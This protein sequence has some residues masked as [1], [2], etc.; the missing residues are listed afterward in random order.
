MGLVQVLGVSGSSRVLCSSGKEFVVESFSDGADAPVPS[1]RVQKGE[2]FIRGW[3]E[4]ATML[5]DLQMHQLWL[6]IERQVL[7]TVNLLH[8]IRNQLSERDDL[9]CDTIW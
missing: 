6:V 2:K 8:V 7:G 1:A 3:D 5:L 9:Y 4:S